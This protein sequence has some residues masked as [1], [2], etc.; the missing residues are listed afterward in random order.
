MLRPGHPDTVTVLGNLALLYASQGQHARAAL[1]FARV[2]ELHEKT[3]GAV[4]RTVAVD[5]NNLAFVYTNLERYEEARS[6]Y[7]RA[8]EIS[9]RGP[10]GTPGPGSAADWT[11]GCCAH[12]GATDTTAS[13]RALTRSDEAERM[14]ICMGVT[15]NEARTPDPAGQRALP[16]TDQTRSRP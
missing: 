14:L 11:G 5:L 13:T 16:D 9:S 2:I 4:H 15:R 7:A 6:L 3:L 1:L 8:I 10:W 12:P